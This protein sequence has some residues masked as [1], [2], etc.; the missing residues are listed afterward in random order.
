VGLPEIVVADS[1]NHA[2]IVWRYDASQPNNALILRQGVDI[3]GPLSPS[4]CPVGSAGTIRGGGP[5]T[6]A[7]F[8]GDGVADVAL[9]GGVGYAVFSGAKVTDSAVANADTILWIKQTQ[10][11]SSAATGSSV[12]DF[13]GDGK[14]EVV[15]ADEKNLHVYAG[16][17]GTELF[18]TCNTNGTLYE[19]PLVADVDNDGQ[20]DLI[21]GSNS[22]SSFKCDDNTKTSGIRIF[23]DANGAWVR[24]RRVWNQ[25]PY[26]VTNVAEDGTIPTV[27]A[28]NYLQPRLNNFRQNV[29]PLGEFSAP[30]LV[31]SVFPNCKNP[32]G[33]VA[34]VRNIGEASAVAGI[35][36]GFYL[37]D[38]NN[39]GQLLG[40]AATTKVLYSVESEDVVL[41][42]LNPPP[43]VTDGTGDLYA[44]VAD[45]PVPQTFHECRTDNNQSEA[46][47]GACHE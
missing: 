27:E 18:T 30:D 13:D 32:Y 23:G 2:L 31:V 11:C 8:N 1:V 42:L 5:P 28:P 39:G 16:I 26:H 10:D 20:A 17:D 29:Q 37:G 4:L 14:A 35:P 12:F 40:T 25:H 19:Y 22:Y 9:A 3:N 47:H 43:A 44:V 34:R 7:D 46:G 36:V 21:V 15:Y 33:L 24:T 38:P 6:I 41:E 45:G